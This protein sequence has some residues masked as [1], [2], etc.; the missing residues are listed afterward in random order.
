MP[1][2]IM[3]SSAAK[4]DINRSASYNVNAYFN[5]PSTYAEFLAIGEIIKK[6]L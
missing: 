5:K 2:I 4:A 1:T 3:T 6:L